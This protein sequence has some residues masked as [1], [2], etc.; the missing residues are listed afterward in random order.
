MSLMSGLY[1][2]VTGLQTSQNALNTTAH[3]LTN[4]ETQGYVRQQVLLGDKIY[5]T[6][7]RSDI[8]EQQI[9]LGVEYSKVRQ[10]R[11]YFLDLSYRRESGRAAFYETNYETTSE[12]E[13]LLGEFS[14]V[15]FQDSLADLWTSVQELQKDPTSGVVQGQ[16]VTKSAELIERAQSVYQGLSDYQDNLNFRVK[17]KVDRINELGQNIYNLNI[18][19]GK[20]ECGGDEGKAIEVAND[21]RDQRNAAVDELSS[22]VKISYFTNSDGNVEVSIEGIPFVLRDRVFEM[23]LVTEPG[24][25]FYTPVW[26]QNNNQSVFEE[27]QEISTVA[28]S[29][30]GELKSVLFCRGDRRANYTDMQD[31]MYN[32]GAYDNLLGREAIP[33]N[34]SVVMRIQAELD[35]M[36]HSLM[37]EVNNI[38]CDEKAA[39][40][41]GATPTYTNE[42]D[43]GLELFVRLGTERYSFDGTNYNYIAEN[44]ANPHVDISK[45][46]TIANIKINPDLLKQ[47]TLLSFV[48]K[49]QRAD[50]TKADAIAE[51]F[52][53][54]FAPLNPN[55]TKECNYADYY[56]AIVAG[57][58]NDGSVYK[59]IMEA[60]QATSTQLDNAR[61]MVTGVSSNEELTNMVKFQNAYNAASRYINALNEMLGHLIEKLG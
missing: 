15:E 18:E 31:P 33:T 26:P 17:E 11:D 23:G 46:Y 25:G 43:C 49:D 45:M 1:V 35:N 29:D 14:G 39:I 40:D 54:P 28:N 32:K 51:A 13:T 22:L 59:S 38:L 3:N 53:T 5:N 55:V 50:Q 56:S 34:S 20:I 2:G 52:N 10:V 19:I 9:G 27:T 7:G 16:F 24:T 47:P 21:L 44:T 60:Q 36:C 57:L 42:E 6:V 37:T 58:G 12:I 48:T 41:S 4:I 61:N 8:S 30:I